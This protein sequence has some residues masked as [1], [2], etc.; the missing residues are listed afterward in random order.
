[1]DKKLLGQR[2][3][4]ARI[5]RDLTIDELASTVGLNK[6]TI[7]RY[8]RGEIESP[9]LPVIESIG[10]ALSTN[11]SWLIGKSQDKTYSPDKSKYPQLHY[12]NLFQPLKELRISHN[13]SVEEVAYAV[14][15]SAE[16]YQ[17]IES[18]SNTDCM[19]AAAIAN[20]LYTS[21]DHILS[22]N[23]TLGESQAIS[24]SLCT[25]AENHRI[26]TLS[27]EETD[28]LRKYR[29]LDDPAK[30]RI[31]N[32]LEYEYNSIPGNKANPAPKEA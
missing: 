19:T 18:G 14:G 8:E 28:L 1:M 11:P 2:I 3:K 26:G 31:R 7:S 30:G 9:K 16:E 25:R 24:H 17:A 21:L 23:G 29:A 32:A 15:I 22:F 12:C 5:A 6:S 20:Y 10:S 27:F 4:E 13:R